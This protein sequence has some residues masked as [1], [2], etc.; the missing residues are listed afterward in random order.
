M[1]VGTF[2]S[3]SE[4]GLENITKLSTATLVTTLSEAGEILTGFCWTVTIKWTSG[5]IRTRIYGFVSAVAETT[6][7][8]WNNYVTLQICQ[9]IFRFEEI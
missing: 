3:K 5:R 9:N 1:P 8:R 2:L 4:L 7:T 6:Q